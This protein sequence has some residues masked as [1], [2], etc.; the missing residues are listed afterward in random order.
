MAKKTFVDYISEEDYPRWQELVT[1]MEEG[2]KAAKATGVRGKTP[3]EKAASIQAKIEKLK[4][5]L[6]AVNGRLDAIDEKD[7]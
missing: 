6:E 3:E 4:A 7:A 2:A 1:K 5:Q